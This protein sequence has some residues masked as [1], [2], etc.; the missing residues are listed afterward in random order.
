MTGTHLSFGKTHLLP[1]LPQVVIKLL[2]ATL[3]DQASMSHVA[4]L[5]AQDPGL[6]SQILRLANSPLFGAGQSISSL[7]QSAVNLGLQTIQNLAVSLSVYESFSDVSRV[8]GFSLGKFW[9][10]SLSVAEC[11]RFLAFHSDYASPEEAL[12]AGLLHD[13]GQ[14][15]LARNYPEDYGHKI[16]D[17]DCDQIITVEKNTWDLDHAQAGADVLEHWQLRPELCDAVRYHHG[18]ASEVRDAP[19]LVRLV[20]MADRLAHYFGGSCKDSWETLQDLAK[21]MLD[22]SPDVLEELQESIAAEVERTASLFG[23]DV[24]APEERLIPQAIGDEEEY[25]KGLR[26]KALDLSLLVGA[27]QSMVSVYRR[28]EL[29]DAFFHSL[30]LL[31]D[32]RCV[33]FAEFVSSDSL[34]GIKALGSSHDETAGRI[35][36]PCSSG[37]IWDQAFINNTPIHIEEF[38][39]DHQPSVTDKE[40]EEFLKNSFIVVPVSSSEKKIGVAVIGISQ[41]EWESKSGFTSVLMLLARQMAL[42]LRGYQYRELWAKER[43]IN[44][45]ILDAAPVGV[46]LAKTDGGSFFWNPKASKLLGFEEMPSPPEKFNI[47]RHLSFKDDVRENV[48]DEIGKGRTAELGPLMFKDPSGHQSGWLNVKAVPLAISGIPGILVVLEDVTSSQLLEKERQ[49]RTNWLKKE[50]T[51]RTKQ[52][53][54]AQDQ[55]IQAERLGATSELAG[56]VAHE[57]NNPLGIIKNL[58]EIIKSR[59]IESER[60]SDT[61]SAIHGEINRIADIISGLRDF[62]G[63]QPDTQEKSRGFVQHAMRSLDALM[64]EPLKQKGVILDFDAGEKLPPVRLSDDGIKHVLIN[65]V[66]NAEEALG[67][68][69][70]IHVRAARDPD[71][72][73]D[74]VIEVSDTGRGISHRVREHLFDPFITTK[75][76]GHSGLGLS[77]CYGL[78]KAAGG[79]IQVKERDGWRTLVEIRLPIF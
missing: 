76:P 20:F 26:S 54:E 27:L 60:E 56:K 49:Q 72:P 52:L 34:Q 74:M 36:I 68:K 8:P 5:A 29:Y 33:L 31:F 62:S 2:E 3:D 23:M 64:V 59:G 13:L 53:K 18:S 40:I 57:V 48:L 69:G 7:S 42:S 37:S 67:E 39:R 65:L 63:S 14:L 70:R 17:A 50:L 77:V 78:I 6:A 51:K 35:K 24:S 45:A 38:L 32:F 47:W 19:Q 73:K 28:E 1:S 46:L 79:S 4:T 11:T 15:L 75:G 12:V 41:K 25:R 71:N 22:V 61:I 9:W 16:Q 58:L 21:D 30:A 66:K 55:I 44:A 43:Y 10:H